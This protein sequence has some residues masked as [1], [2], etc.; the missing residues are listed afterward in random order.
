MNGIKVKARTAI[1][2]GSSRGIGRGIA[3]KLAECG[4]G[5]IAVHYL[6]NKQAAEETARLLRERGTEPV[7]VQADVTRPED[8]RRMFAE[9]KAGLGSLDIFVANARPDVQHF[10]Q[11]VLDLTAEHWRAAIDSQATALLHSAREAVGMMGRGGRIVAVT[12]A[13]GA[14]MGSWRSWAAMGP[15][16]AAMEALL[17]YLAWDL[18]GRGITANAVSPGATDDS[19]FST[20]PPEV[21]DALRGWAGAGW[22]PMGR[23]TT[24]ADVGDAVALL[25]SEQAGFIT[26]QTL[27]VDGGASLA[28]A[29]FPMEFQRG[30]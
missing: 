21:L 16:K 25:C 18:A 3:L 28:S 7:L 29:D 4:V 1:I 17:R 2:T 13:P 5:Q 9:A 19:V 15:A 10:Y 14:K 6:R 27:H 24:P 30:A 23:L 22:V 8:I 20:L 11:P 26:G 12:Y